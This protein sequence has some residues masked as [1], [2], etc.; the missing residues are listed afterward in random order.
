MLC[1]YVNEIISARVIFLTQCTFN[2]LQGL[3]IGAVQNAMTRDGLDPA[4]MDLD[5]DKSVASQ[6]NVELVDKGPP[7]KEDPKY[8]KY[9]KMLKMVCCFCSLYESMYFRH[10]G[11]SSFSCCNRAFQ[12]V[13]SRTL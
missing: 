3:P 4:I 7:L 9:F 11:N 8:Q 12:W 6:M 1:S 2:L 10:V 13:L 5:H